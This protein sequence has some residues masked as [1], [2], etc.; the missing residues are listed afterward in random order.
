METF[1]DLHYAASTGDLAS[2]R[3]LVLSGIDL[4]RFDDVGFTAL[5]HAAHKEHIQVIL[6]LLS[7]GANVNAQ[8]E[9]KI[10]NTPL[11]EVAGYCSYH[12]VKVLIELGADPCIAGWMGLSA[13][14]RASERQ[15]DDGVYDLILAAAPEAEQVADGNG[16]QAP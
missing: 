9:S 12:V 3:A 2:V 15:R 5:H 10:G 8:D 14:D 4:D 1:T 11:G 13:L 16:A 6:E 7:K